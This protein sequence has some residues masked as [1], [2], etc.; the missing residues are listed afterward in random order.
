V[1]LA[2]LHGQV[3][4]EGRRLQTSVSR[5]LNDHERDYGRATARMVQECATSATRRL[6]L[7]REDIFRER[8]VLSERATRRL[9]AVRRDLRHLSDVIAAR[10]FRRRGWLLAA[11]ESGAP[12]RSTMDLRR[13]QRLALHLHDGRADAVVNGVNP[14]QRSN[15]Q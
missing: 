5:Q 12:V 15:P 1:R 13:G 4:A 10:D 11:Q 14:D 7:A 6:R 2:R 9:N 3:G 8:S